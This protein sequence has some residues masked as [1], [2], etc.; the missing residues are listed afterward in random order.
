MKVTVSK[1]NTF[2]FADEPE[3]EHLGK[4]EVCGSYSELR[5]YGPNDKNICAEC[6]L[7]NLPEVFFNIL[8]RYIKERTNNVFIF[9]G[10]HKN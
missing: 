5:P 6:A 9:T 3:Q 8:N 7:A 10:A 4:C 2:I 1:N